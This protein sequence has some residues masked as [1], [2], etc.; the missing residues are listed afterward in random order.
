MSLSAIDIAHLVFAISI[1][2][3]FAHGFGYIF[4]RIRQPQVIGEI[5]GG[6]VLGPTFL[7]IVAPTWYQA[8]F[9][10]NTPTQIVLGAIY[11][12][13]LLLLM[14][15][16][17]MEMVSSFREN[18]KKT[19]LII[20]ATGIIVPFI[21]S[22]A[23]LHFIDPQQHMGS[24]G[25]L[26]AFT[27]VFAIAIAVTSIPVIS[28]IL[29]DLK[30]LDTSF[31][32]IVLSSALIEDVILYILLSIALA[33]VGTDGHAAFGL[34]ALLNLDPTS[35]LGFAYHVVITLLFFGVS[36]AL[37]PKIFNWLDSFRFNLPRRRSPLA[38]LLLILFLVSG[39]ATLL[40]ITPML[41]AFVAGIVARKLR[42][43][44]EASRDA[45]KEFSFAFFIPIYFA[46]IGLKLDLVHQFDIVFFIGFFVSACL[47]KLLC[48]YGGSR[49]AG[50]SSQASFN[51]SVAMNA[52]G[53]PG[54]VLASLALDAHIV[55]EGF[56][57]I[58]VMLAIVTS[59]LAGSW[60][61]YIVRRGAVLR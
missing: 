49:L 50:E 53:G 59:L 57:T 27:L 16:S 38:F 43:D 36:L 7:K 8:F 52:R 13:G 48:V 14:F 41:G 19:A 15:C 29:F 24:A 46:I 51:L 33:I 23:L 61:G 56:Y 44:A 21:A 11:N 40:G 47:I 4:Q 30:I 45:I 25:N 18:E 5:L 9:F 54:I 34:P 22:F 37:G 28:R 35:N 26:T 10:E 39:M 2:L 1:L 12:L 60:L 17:G 20:S 6:I 3:F 32:R 42:K 58:L 31:A 55:N